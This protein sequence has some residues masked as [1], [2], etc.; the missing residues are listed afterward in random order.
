MET[1]RHNRRKFL[2]LGSTLAVASSIAPITYGASLLEKNDFRTLEEKEPIRLFSNENPYGP[3]Q[4]V[5]KAITEHTSRVN[6]YASFNSYATDELRRKI[7]KQNGINEDQVILG[8]GSFEIL[9]MLTRAFGQQQD[10]IIVPA[11]TFNVTA[12]F[13]DRIFDHKAKRILLTDAMDIDLKTTKSAITKATRLVYICNPNNPTGKALSAND[14]L[15]FCKEVA[16]SNCTVAI[17][18]A[19]VELMDPKKKPDTIKLLQEKYN[20][21]IIRTFSKAY[22]LAGLRVGYAMGLS[23]TIAKLNHE[24]YNFD[25]LISNPGVVAAITALEDP[26]YVNEYQK[27]NSEVKKYMEDSLDDLGLQYVKSDT[28]FM[29]IEVKDVKRLKEELKTFGIAIFPSGGKHYP[30]WAR[31]S[32][33]TLPQMQSFMKAIRTMNWLKV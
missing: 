5:T 22:G 7:A 14:L 3:S 13:A 17:D 12:A 26:S 8:H 11:T 10:S 31:I 19:Y 23:E 21:L 6:R 15:S 24:F 4:Q 18:E 16:S 33:G 1:Y 2:Q 28:N 32:I 25:G 30:T 9:C 27:K 20:V 29:L